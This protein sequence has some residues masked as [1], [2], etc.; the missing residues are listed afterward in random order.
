M[1]RMALAVALVAV[2]LLLATGCRQARPAAQPTAGPPATT[3]SSPAST[4]AWTPPATTPPTAGAVTYPA[5][6]HGAV[7]AAW[8]S[9][10]T[11]RLAL[12]TSDPQDF[13]AIA[14]RPDQHWTKVRCDGA[15]GSE[16]CSYENRAGDAIVIRVSWEA[17]TQ[18]R[19]HAADLQ[20]WDP[21]S[22]PNDPTAYARMFVNAWVDGYRTRM[23]LL[24]T[25]VVVNHFM[26]LDLIDMSYTIDTDGAA[27]HTYARITHGGGFDQTITIVNDTVS[28]RMPHAIDGVV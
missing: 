22:Y 2:P 15:M 9:H 12:L 27:G 5:D 7:L 4:P 1:K 21:M 24:S 6:Y 23:L 10:D 17:Y 16:Y 11:Q 26:A 18:H 8:A 19:W 13:L 20:S 3:A 14:G 25:P 28:R